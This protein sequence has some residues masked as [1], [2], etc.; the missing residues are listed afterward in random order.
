MDVHQSLTIT[1]YVLL[2]M[3]A[4]LVISYWVLYTRRLRT[5]RRVGK[6]EGISMATQRKERGDKT[7]FI[8]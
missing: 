5:P 3:F 1:V 8:G 4:L 2:V 7:G 6:C